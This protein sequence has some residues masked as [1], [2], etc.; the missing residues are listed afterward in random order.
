MKLI[1]SGH[2]V[3]V[4]VNQLKSNG[5]EGSRV[6]NVYDITNREICFKLNPNTNTN[7]D[8]YTNT[9]TDTNINTDANEDVPCDANDDVDDSVSTNK[10]IYLILDSGNKFYTKNSPFTALR[11]IPTS[12]CSK[13]R[14]HLK[15]KRIEKF[16]QIGFDRVIDIQFGTDE[17]AYH[18]ISEFYA[19]GNIILTDNQYKILTLIHPYTYKDGDSANVKVAVG[20]IYP[21]EF[22]TTDFTESLIN[23]EGFREWILEEKEKLTK[24]IKLKQFLSRSP[25]SIFGPVLIDHT[26]GEL[27]IDTKNKINNES[28]IEIM[29]SDEVITHIINKMKEMY[30]MTNSKGYILLDDKDDHENIIPCLY[31]QCQS[32]KYIEYPTFVDAVSDYFSKVDDIKS[33]PKENKEESKVKHGDKEDRK[34]SN[35]KSQIDSMNDLRDKNNGKV[36]SISENVEVLQDILNYT[37][38]VYKSYAPDLIQLY[39]DKAWPGVVVIKELIHLKELHIEIEQVQ[40]IIKTDQS[41]YSNLSNI[42]QKGKEIKKKQDRAEIKLIEIEKENKKRAKPTKSTAYQTV[43]VIGKKKDNW[44][45]IFNWFIT[46]EGFI[47]VSG[48]TADQNE[49]L[50]KKYLKKEDLYVHSDVAGSGSCVV[51]EANI[52]DSP[53][54]SL[55][56]AGSFV[57]CKTKAWKDNS[58]DK[59]WW[60]YPEQVSK[61][62]E[63]GEYITKGSF[64][65]RGKKNYLTKPKLELGLSLLFK[66]KDNVKLQDHIDEDVEYAIPVCA[67]YVSLSKNKFKIKITPGT[68]K[69]GKT[70]K[71]MQSYLFKQ[72]NMYEHASMKKISVDE[73]HRVLV[74]GI[75]AHLGV[76]R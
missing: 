43:E 19:S 62:T 22:A 12:F 8:T 34:S 15:N 40:F 20:H 66:Q 11:Q 41:A 48:K 57:V 61:T 14:K 2:D 49:T 74:T 13:L 10:K 35:I 39:L 18:V 7:T 53:I 59:A 67:P 27:G 28:D 58:S 55:L 44:Y 24:K 33:I 5:I 63:P 32:K 69:I 26:L 36:S 17:Y 21:K 73:F 23:P 56:E 6:S 70:L 75:R 1:L 9:N 4:L 16:S 65:I 37:N 64:I 60:V 50:V 31:H 47:V 68:Q 30:L 72:G 76:K 54:K 45:E 51:K 25:L 42:Y 3:T 29:F 71:E 46:S 38:I 52:P